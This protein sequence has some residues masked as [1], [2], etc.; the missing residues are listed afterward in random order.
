MAVLRLH[1]LSLSSSISY[2]WLV[3]LLSLAD[4]TLLFR[5][6]HFFLH[7]CSLR[8]FADSWPSEDRLVSPLALQTKL[9]DLAQTCS[10]SNKNLLELARSIG[11]R[12]CCPPQRFIKISAALTTLLCSYLCT[13]LA[14]NQ[15]LSSWH[16]A[17]LL[18]FAISVPNAAPGTKKRWCCWMNELNV[19]ISWTQTAHYR[20]KMWFF[21][22]Q[23]FLTRV[24][25][26]HV[27]TY[28]SL[29]C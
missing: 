29:S 4:R 9:C 5:V 16:G 17:L 6:T 7:S 27:V 22:S 24:F 20:P 1:L 21:L 25:S 28:H 8:L 18:T 10:T 23:Q 15:D 14:S 11:D 2:G 13:C 26:C 3:T 19:L 12:F